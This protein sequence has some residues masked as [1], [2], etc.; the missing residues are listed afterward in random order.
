MRRCDA[1][2]QAAASAVSSKLVNVSRL[3]EIVVK[4]AMVAHKVQPRLQ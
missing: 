3:L 1:A 4:R 2:L